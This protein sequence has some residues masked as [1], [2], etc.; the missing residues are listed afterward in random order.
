MIDVL[1]GAL[2]LPEADRCTLRTWYERHR[3]FFRVLEW[4]EE[5]E[6]VN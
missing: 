1:A 4:H 5:G 2:D 6:E 3:S